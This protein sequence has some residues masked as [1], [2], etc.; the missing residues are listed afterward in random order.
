M[1]NFQHENLEV[2]FRSTTGEILS[3]NKFSETHVSSSGGGGY[4]GKHGGHVG[5]PNV[6]SES[7]T[8]HE[9]WI[10][11]E[12][13]NEKSIQLSGH[14]IPLRE[15][16]KITLISAGVSGK[17]SRYFSVLINHN[18]NNHWF[19]NKAA[20]LNKHLKIEITSGISITIAV[21]L[22]WLVV[23][24]TNSIGTGAII[25]GTFLAYRF[26]RKMSRVSKVTKALDKHLE[27]LVQQAY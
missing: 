17:D 25:A 14:D 22:L 5:A 16:Q 1:E 3:Q 7:I 21:G 27:L 23:Y 20:D 12:D 6:Q 4:V 11:T 26:I 10:K 24:L 15:G 13:G 2:E 19:I 18:A 9:F 8:N